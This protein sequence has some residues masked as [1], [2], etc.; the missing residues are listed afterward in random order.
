[1]ESQSAGDPGLE[2]RATLRWSRSVLLEPSPSLSD[3]RTDR[4]EGHLSP[5]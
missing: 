2:T 5:E 3:G 1:M 4:A